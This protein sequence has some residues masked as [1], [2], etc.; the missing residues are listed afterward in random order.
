M[1]ET[2]R[3]QDAPLRAML[4]GVP[5][6]VRR[7]ALLQ[8]SMVV[9]CGLAA[10]LVATMAPR[11]D[12][13]RQQLALQP[14]A[15]TAPWVAEVHAFADRLHRGFGIRQDTA[16]EFSEWILEASE[17]QG[18]RPELIA[19]LVLTESS[20]RKGARSVVGAIGPAQVRPQYWRRFCGTA[21]LSDPAENIYCG[22]QVL[23][24]YRESC[25][26]TICALRAYNVGPKSRRA[27]AAQR[28]VAKIDARLS[29]LGHALVV[30]PLLKL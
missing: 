21:D 13:L 24:L 30:E 27:R 8:L 16:L 10:V 5:S 29:Q 7:L 3:E 25:G 1:R 15:L 4:A 22:A 2:G 17:R 14:Q 20:F 26:D 11:S 23:A 19:S 9:C 12:M 28:Y 6:V 18:F